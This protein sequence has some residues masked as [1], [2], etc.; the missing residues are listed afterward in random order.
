MSCNTYLSLSVAEDDRLCDG[1]SVVEITEGVKLPLLSL[2]GHKEL[3]DAFQR[4]LITA[5]AS[6][7]LSLSVAV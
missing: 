7:T 3:F 6:G 1:E 2:D 5:T 4:Q